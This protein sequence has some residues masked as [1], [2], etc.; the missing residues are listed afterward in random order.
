VVLHDGNEPPADRDRPTFNDYALFGGHNFMDCSNGGRSKAGI[1]DCLCLSQMDRF[2]RS[3]NLDPEA[4]GSY[5]LRK[6]RRARNYHLS[7]LRELTPLIDVDPET[8]KQYDEELAVDELNPR[9]IHYGALSLT[10]FMAPA[11]GPVM[12]NLYSSGQCG[13]SLLLGS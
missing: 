4:G 12:M 11:E 10:S 6:M 5:D 2:D 8:G 7:G 13:D 9:A 3:L 1:Q